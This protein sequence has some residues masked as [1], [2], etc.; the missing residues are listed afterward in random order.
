V[1]ADHG[2]PSLHL[3]HAALERASILGWATWSVS[4]SHDRD[5]AIAFVVAMTEPTPLP[6]ESS[7]PLPMQ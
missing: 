6:N 1:R 7:P 3:H 2:A 5:R 4:L